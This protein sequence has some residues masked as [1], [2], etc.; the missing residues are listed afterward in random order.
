MA[1]PD[2]PCTKEKATTSPRLLQNATRALTQHTPTLT[3]PSTPHLDCNQ[4]QTST[5]Q[6]ARARTTP[7]T[8]T[9]P[10][11]PTT[12]CLLHAHQMHTHAVLR[13]SAPIR[14]PR[15]Q[16]GMRCKHSSS[17][18]RHTP[19]KF[20]GTRTTRAK[21]AL[22]K[23]HLCARNMQ[24]PDVSRSRVARV[25]RVVLTR[26]RRVKKRSEAAMMS[27][28]CLALTGLDLQ[29]GTLHASTKKRTGKAQSETSQ[30]FFGISDTPMSLRGRYITIFNDF[31]F[32]FSR[33]WGMVHL[34]H[35]TRGVESIGYSTSPSARH[36]ELCK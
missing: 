4:R 31:V 8:R 24:R 28:E 25:W 5:L 34:A 36:G 19:R 18:A 33:R 10:Q 29:C 7:R 11:H 1:L 20:R 14:K 22:H 13:Q 35:R 16:S 12:P 26:D 27:G 2:C 9:A 30:D 6:M 17:S 32:C 15:K 21:P 23:L 3:I